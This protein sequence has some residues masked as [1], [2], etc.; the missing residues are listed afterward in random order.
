MP[1]FICKCNNVIDLSGIPSKHQFLFVADAEYDKFKGDIN[2]DD[3]YARMQIFIEC[4]VC[5]RIHIFWNGFD[6]LPAVY[7][8]EE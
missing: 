2:T 5:S 4:P 6:N 7:N 3:L 1:K 8:K